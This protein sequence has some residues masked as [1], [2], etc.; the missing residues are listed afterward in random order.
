MFESAFLILL[1]LITSIVWLAYIGFKIKKNNRRLLRQHSVLQVETQ[2]RGLDKLINHDRLN[3]LLDHYAG[4]IYEMD[5]DIEPDEQSSAE[6]SYGL[7]HVLWMME[8]M[9]FFTDEGKLNRW[10]GWVQCCLVAEQLITL[11]EARNDVRD[12]LERL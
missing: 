3:T 5:P 1:A 2:T 10:L 6:E 4:L 11:S 9:V 7:E 12:I 8:K